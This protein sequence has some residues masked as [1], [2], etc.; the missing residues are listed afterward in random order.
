MGQVQEVIMALTDLQV[1]RVSV[2]IDEFGTGYSSLLYLKHFPIQRV[3]IA[4]EFIADIDNNP[5]NA[6]IAKAIIS[7][8]HS[9]GMAVTAVGVDN[10]VQLDFLR[11]HGCNEVAGPFLSPPLPPDE[12]AR[13]LCSSANLSL[14]GSREKTYQ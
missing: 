3:K 1:H 10:E 9:L 14:A 13:M 5:D 12:I 7:M 4:Q 8:T 11:R 2:A 6:A